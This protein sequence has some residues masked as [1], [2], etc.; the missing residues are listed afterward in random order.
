MLTSTLRIRV[1]WAN[2]DPAGI[3]FNPHYYI[4]MDAG[5]HALMK[6][7]GIDMASE[8]KK[9]NQFMGYPLVTSTAQFH[10]P[11][12]L[13]DVLTLSTTVEKI[14]NTSF[15]TCHTFFRST[16]FGT[17]VDTADSTSD[18]V[19]AKANEVVLCTG[20]EVRVW[21]GTDENNH[22]IALRVPDKVRESL[23]INEIIDSSV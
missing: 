6:A 8:I 22:L 14:G 16:A 19:I 2:C 4:W 21:G 1:E 20:S 23:S 12:M 7:A 10:A 3:I 5:S 9:D 18:S 13:G 15:T 11:A 17:A